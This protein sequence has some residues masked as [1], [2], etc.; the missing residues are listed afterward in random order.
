MG[1]AGWWFRTQA[2]TAGAWGS[3][4]HYTQNQEEGMSAGTQLS[5]SFNDP[6]PWD[7]GPHIQGESSFL[8]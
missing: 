7:G 3:W 8:H 2:V 4:S 5:F 1:K 6:N